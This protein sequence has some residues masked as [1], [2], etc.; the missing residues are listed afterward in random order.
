[1]LTESFLNLSRTPGVTGLFSVIGSFGAVDGN[2]TFTEASQGESTCYRYEGQGICLSAELRHFENG[3]ILRRDTLKNLTDAPI[4]LHMLSSRFC[5]EGNAYDVYTQYSGWQHESEGGWAPLVTEISASAQ[6]IR[7]CDGATPMMALYNRHNGK[8]TVLHLLPNA[9]WQMRARRQY[10]SDRELTVVETGFCNAGLRLTVAPGEVISLPSVILFEASSRTDLDAHKLHEVFL[11]LYPRRRLPILYNTWLAF[12]D[13]LDPDALLAEAD[14]AAELGFEAFMVDA[15]WFGKDANWFRSTGD[16]VEN[17]VAGPKGRLL[18]L[19]ERVRARG[20][21][22][23][24]WFEPER[25]S[26]ASDAYAAHPEYFMEGGLLDFA[27]PEARAYILDAI[28]R[29]IDQYSV[30]WV[31]FDSNTSIPHDPTG[32]AF[33]RYMAGRRE[34]IESLRGRYPDLYMT[35]C[36]GG[37][38]RMDLTD[39]T[40][41]DSFWFTDNQGSYD[42]LTIIKD[43]LKRMPTALLERWNVQVAVPGI[44][45][46]TPQK[47]GAKL[48]T[49]NNATWSSAIRVQDSFTEGF[50][51]GGPLGFSCRLTAFP[52]EYREYFRSMIATYKGDRDFFM[53]A[54]TY[55]LTDD[56]DVTVIEYASPALDRCE[57]L[58]FTKNTHASSVRVYPAVCPDTEYTVGDGRRT[59][60]EISENGILFSSLMRD[61]C[62]HLTLTRA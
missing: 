54:R 19:S 30:G 27:N 33:Y 61:S 41:F 13:Q 8:T 22:F 45:E 39:A 10:L 21:T 32:E 5:L 16:W 44:P 34:F 6:G 35:G 18:E 14:A 60:A 42:G 49:C 46:I 29:V 55:I 40:L 20:M 53:D 17:T 48:L 50:L 12:F 3:A 62:Q 59:G 7:T 57:I 43:T 4:T 26:T 36:A 38:F 37:G 1:M 56:C 2:V 15:G 23:G 11:S 24:L 52:E 47:A 28:C 51:R 25:A 31:K 58:L 9:Q